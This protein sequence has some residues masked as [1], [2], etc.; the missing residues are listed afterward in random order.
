MS[1]DDFST[2]G[3]E[4]TEDVIKEKMMDQNE[5]LLKQLEIT[6]AENEKL[7]NLKEVEVVPEKEESFQEA[8]IRA[9]K[10]IDLKPITKDMREHAFSHTGQLAVKLTDPSKHYYWE[11]KLDDKLKTPNTRNIA[12]RRQEGYEVTKD[13]SGGMG[14][15]RA[16]GGSIIETHDLVLMETSNEN[17]VKRAMIPVIRAKAALTAVETDAR[18]LGLK[19]KMEGKKKQYDNDLQMMNDPDIL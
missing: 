14:G 5:E 10:E 9:A 15:S 8:M 4:L 3:E 6:K 11:S 19:G 13:P 17:A 18:S 2:E 12:K 7:K 1:K 16:G